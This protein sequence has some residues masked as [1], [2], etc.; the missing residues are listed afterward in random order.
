MII[1]VIEGG[2][3][4]IAEGATLLEEAVIMKD[5]GCWE[6]MNA[7]GDAGSSL[8]INGRETVRPSGPGD[9]EGAVPAVWV[10]KSQL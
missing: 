7:A 1:V 5:L 4:G 10:V 8:L 6:A 3:P 9:T 2:H